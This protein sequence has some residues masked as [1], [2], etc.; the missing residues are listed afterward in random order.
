MSRFQFPPLQNGEDRTRMH[1]SLCCSDML[2]TLKPGSR[3]VS[4]QH[5][6]YYL[7]SLLLPPP[8]H[9]GQAP[10][11]HTLETMQADTRSPTQNYK[12]KNLPI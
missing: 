2:Y 6:L 9:S 5:V 11:L 12:R 1:I 4:L 3:A 7:I 10:S 8:A